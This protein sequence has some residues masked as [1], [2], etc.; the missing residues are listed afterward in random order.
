MG[1]HYIPKID[2]AIPARR[3]GYRGAA[4]AGPGQPGLGGSAAAPY[5]SEASLTSSA[6]RLHSILF[7]S[8]ATCL[9]TVSTDD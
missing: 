9:R 4:R 8:D 7:S 3:D 5:S 1:A 2:Y 6:C